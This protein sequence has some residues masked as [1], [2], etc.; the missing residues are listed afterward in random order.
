MFSRPDR[1]ELSKKKRCVA[2]KRK[3][4]EIEPQGNRNPTLREA[5]VFMAP[6]LLAH[7]E[8]VRTIELK[9]ETVTYVK[10]SLLKYH[11]I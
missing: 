3:R 8:L 9:P 1:D 2:A 5:S 4:K 11:F 7:N 6:K 10:R